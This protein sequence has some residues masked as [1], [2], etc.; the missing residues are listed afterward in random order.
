MVRIWCFHCRGQSSIPGQAMLCFCAPHFI[1][2]YI[3]IRMSFIDQICL[4]IRGSCYSDKAPQC[5][6]KTATGQDT[7]NKRTIYKYT[8]RQCT[9]SKNTMQYRQSCVYR[10]DVQIRNGKKIKYIYIY[11]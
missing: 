6:I 2:L 9:N 1:L 4:H 7:D 8:N 3:R 10:S 11:F 5:N